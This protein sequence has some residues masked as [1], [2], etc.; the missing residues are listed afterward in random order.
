MI[1]K[2]T[3][4]APRSP[5]RSRQ[6]PPGRGS[7]LLMAFPSA[8]ISGR[9]RRRLHLYLRSCLAL[10]TQVDPEQRRVDVRVTPRADLDAQREICTAV[11]EARPRG[12]TGIRV[13]EVRTVGVGV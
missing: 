3:A 4:Y 6:A 7:I 11:V 5:R 9:G 13:I 8:A 10:Q 12:C 2:R 1:M